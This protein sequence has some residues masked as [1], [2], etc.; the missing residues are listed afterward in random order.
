MKHVL[1]LS[2]CFV[3]LISS[4]TQA[5]EV[6]FSYKD[7]QDPIKVSVDAYGTIT[8]TEFPQQLV[9]NVHYTVVNSPLF[10]KG[11]L[12]TET[13]K[14]VD[15]KL[16]MYKQ[17]SGAAILQK[18]IYAN[19][20]ENN[21]LTVHLNP[22]PFITEKGFVEQLQNAVVKAGVIRSNYHFENTIKLN[23]FM[24]DFDVDDSAF[25]KQLGDEEEVLEKFKASIN[26]SILLGGENIAQL[27][28]IDLGCDIYSGKVKVS[29]RLKGYEENPNLKEVILSSSDIYTLKNYIESHPVDGIKDKK[30]KIYFQLGQAFAGV[31]LSLPEKEKVLFVFNAL[32]DKALDELKLNDEVLL[33]EGITRQLPAADY[34]GNAVL[35]YR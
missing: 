33:S 29:I 21:S 34:E 35:Q 17:F 13:C 4:S 27:N 3:A 22:V 32:V 23:D 2:A 8:F 31:G 5:E 9:G 18:H 24:V 10:K 15:E 11:E 7:F 19:V 20:R 25:I 1:A 28:A 26:E 16:S 6:V 14:Q 12:T 30:A